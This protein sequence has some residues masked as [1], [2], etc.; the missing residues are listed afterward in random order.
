MF[1]TIYIV[2]KI[3][4]M[5]FICMSSIGNVYKVQNKQNKQK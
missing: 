1:Y 4:E 5:Q 2:L 3:L